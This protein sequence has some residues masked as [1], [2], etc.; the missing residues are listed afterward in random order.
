MCTFAR[1][2]SVQAAPASINIDAILQLAIDAI[3]VGARWIPF[4]GL[5]LQ[6]RQAGVM[7]VHPPGHG[8]HLTRETGAQVGQARDLGD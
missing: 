2:S 3:D 5:L 7:P 6:M 4:L 8:L 1:V